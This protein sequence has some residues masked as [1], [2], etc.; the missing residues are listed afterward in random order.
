VRMIEKEFVR[1]RDL[2]KKVTELL[3]VLVLLEIAVTDLVVVEVLPPLPS[4]W[5]WMMSNEEMKKESFSNLNW[6]LHSTNQLHSQLELHEE[7]VQGT[8][9]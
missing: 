1:M 9:V 2:M 6:D 5:F 8:I 3:N 7:D 4:C